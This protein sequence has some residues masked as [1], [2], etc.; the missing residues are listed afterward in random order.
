M[1]TARSVSFYI[2]FHVHTNIN[3]SLCGHTSFSCP[4]LCCTLQ[5]CVFYKSKVY[6]RLASGK[7]IGAIFSNSICFC[8]TFMCVS[9]SHFG[10]SHNISNLFIV[11]TFVTV[12]CDQWSLMSPWPLFWGA[13]NCAHIKCWA[14]EMCVFWLLHQ[15][16][17]PP[18]LSLSSGLPI[19]QDTNSEISPI[20][21]PT[22]A[23]KCSSERNRHISHLKS[24]VKNA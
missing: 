22:K 14:L 4:S 2:F 15:L 21:N 7:F 8:V 20:S 9:E 12:I 18:S 10:N 23:S 11:V 17:I 6:G 1:L 24:N 16:P 3:S 19:P 13:V 5:I